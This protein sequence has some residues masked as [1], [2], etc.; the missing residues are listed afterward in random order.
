MTLDKKTNV[1][2][3]VV[4]LEVTVPAEEFE[5]AVQKSYVKNVKKMNVP[6]F[7]RGKAPRKMIEKMYGAEIFYDDAINEVYPEAYE[8]AVKEAGIEPVDRASVEIISTDADG[9]KFK[10]KV[11]VKPKVSVKEYKGLKVEKVLPSVTAEEVENELKGYQKRQGRIVEVPAG[12]KT[13]EGDTVIFDFEGFCDGKPFEGGKAEDYSLVLGS[14]QFIPGFEEQMV[15]Y[16]AGSEFSV[17]VKFP[18]EYHAEDLKGKDAEFKIKLHEIKR[19]ELPLLDDDFAKDVSDFDT[20]DEFK[21]DLEQ[22]I[23]DR[24]ND[25]A[26]REVDAKLSDMLC[27]VL[28]AEIPSCM[29]ENEIDIQLQNFE[30]RFASQ[31][32]SLQQYLEYTGQEVGSLRNMF[33]EQAEKDVKA[34]LALEKIAEIEKIIINEDEVNEEYNKFASE[35]GMDI[36]KIKS[37]YMTEN[38]MKDL[39]LRKAFEAVKNNAEI[40]E[41]KEPAKEEK[42]PAAKKSAAK[43]ADGDNA[44]T[45]DAEKKPAAKKCATRKPAAKKADDTAEKKPAAKKT[46]AKK[47]ADKE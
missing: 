16:E 38:I 13:A 29:F 6:G 36:E 30:R 31:G 9:F 43:K 26:E 44:S 32:I 34:R 24:K 23:L 3:N 4:E 22:K 28:E 5:K 18:E 37:E 47:A 35:M 15:G 11:T 39:S 25:Q 21:K 14:G 17:N 45:A 12:E 2:T 1:E 41:V 10:A 8:A 33:R 46:T 19:E 40:S 7:R 42:K 27:D 20:L